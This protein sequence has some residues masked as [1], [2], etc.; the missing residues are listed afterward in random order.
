[1]TWSE[2]Y[3]YD[4]STGVVTETGITSNEDSSSQTITIAD[5]TTG[6]TNFWRLRV[7]LAP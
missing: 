5:P 4:A 7:E 2:I 3:R 6:P 1:V